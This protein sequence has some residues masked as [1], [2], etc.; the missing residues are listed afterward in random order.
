[1]LIIGAWGMPQGLR[2][3]P[4]PSSQDLSGQ[5]LSRVFSILCFKVQG[6]PKATDLT[7]QHRYEPPG[8]AFT[9]VLE[10]ELRP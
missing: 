5:D 2:V 1:M 4:F 8:S 10:S 6:E 9:W 3:L 7:A